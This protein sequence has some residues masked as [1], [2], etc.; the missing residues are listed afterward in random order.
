[1]ARRQ[2]IPPAAEMEPNVAQEIMSREKRTGQRD[3]ASRT[4]PAKALEG[5]I[6]PKDKSCKV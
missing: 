6:A 5:H 3:G 2:D 4:L 1:M